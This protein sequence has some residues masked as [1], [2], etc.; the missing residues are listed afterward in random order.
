[1]SERN[2]CTYGRWIRCASPGW[3]N[4]RIPSLVKRMRRESQ[5][6]TNSIAARRL[7]RLRFEFD[8]INCQTPTRTCLLPGHGKCQPIRG[9]IGGQ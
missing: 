9:A 6:G 3:A 8:A 1:M 2:I 5:A 4:I 7:C